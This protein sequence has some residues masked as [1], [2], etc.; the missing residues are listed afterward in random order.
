MLGRC[1]RITKERTLPTGVTGEDIKA[2]EESVLD[3]FDR[4]NPS[5][6][7]IGEDSGRFERKERE[8]ERLF[9]DNLKFPP[10]MFENFK[11]LD[12]GAGSGE[13]TIFYARWGAACTLVDVGRQSLAKAETV[14]ARF[15]P[16]KNDHAFVCKSL[17]D[18]GGDRV[19]DVVVCEGMLHHTADTR[20]GF[21]KLTSFAR[22]GGYVVL[23]IGTASGCFQSMMQRLL[24]YRFANGDDEIVDV[25]EALFPDHID[26][27]QAFGGRS[28]RAI[29]FD[30]FVNPKQD[31]PSISDVLHW[32]DE[33][34]LTLYSA[35][36]P[37]V[38]SLLGDSPNR[39]TFDVRRLPFAAAL[40]EL[41]WMMHGDDDA[42]D[43][44]GL[45]AE[46]AVLDERQRAVTHCINDYSP[47]QGFDLGEFRDRVEALSGCVTDI[48]IG[49]PL[50]D[51]ARAFLQEVEQV[52]AAVD[53]GDFER[54]RTVT[55][56]TKHI[57]R[58]TV[59]LGMNYFI[60][61]KGGATP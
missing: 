20:G 3:V 25:A 37:V 2:T 11:L 27:A 35:W 5:T 57:F 6:Y 8:R 4:E 54:V 7:S 49:K 41:I 52:I 30:A 42:E 31:N 56:N 22:P 19:F 23:G 9:H 21:G 29:I 15:A 59:G 16:N 24:I 45:L 39:P 53:G 61:R 36:P 43:L 58:G 50:V 14:F 13:H 60:G 34:D 51:R 26:R 32:F 46:L 12:V 40:A 47:G 33:N 1:S 10:K 38:P 28:R 17:F 55:A 18:F 48:R 44:P